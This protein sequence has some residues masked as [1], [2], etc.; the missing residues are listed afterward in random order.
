MMRHLLLVVTLCMAIP[1]TVFSQRHLKDM[2]PFITG[3]SI[4][5]GIAYDS[6]GTLYIAEWG[7]E[8]VCRYDDKGIRTVVTDGVGDPSGIAFDGNDSLYVAHYSGGVVYKLDQEGRA[9]IYASGFN[10]PAGITFIDGLLYVPSRDDGE[11]IRIERDGRKTVVAS[12]LP[13]P[14][15]VLKMGSKLVISCLSGPIYTVDA[16]GKAQILTPG[17]MGSGINIV[18]DG[19]DA[20]YIC[21]ISSGTVERITMD[22]ERTVLAEGFS[23]PLGIA[24]RPDGNLVFSAWG[25]FAAYALDVK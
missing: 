17:V 21:V 6:S 2:S 24:R 13:Q 10:V 1:T 11:V 15:S 4:P 20:F 9:T 5:G 22:G 8:R 7:N 18:P 12:G 19:I 23:T 25:Q 3:L 16:T 14:V